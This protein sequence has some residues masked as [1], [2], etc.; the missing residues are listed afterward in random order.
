MRVGTL[1]DCF[2]VPRGEPE[3]V[4]AALDHLRAGGADVIVSNQSHR[5]WGRAL[6]EAGFL[7]GPSNFIFAAAPALAARLQPFAATCETVHLTRGD[8]DGPINL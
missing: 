1:V 8:G 5:G 4:A 7:R 2:A 3:V 6:T